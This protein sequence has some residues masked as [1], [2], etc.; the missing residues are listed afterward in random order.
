MKRASYRQGLQWI[1]VN[2]EPNELETDFVKYQIS[3]I[4]LADL[5]GVDP[6]KVAK[7]VLLTRAK[8]ERKEAI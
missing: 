1:A 2:D 7:D 4:L 6:V 5:F 8:I 3:V